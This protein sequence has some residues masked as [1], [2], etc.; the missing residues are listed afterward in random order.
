[1]LVE[2]ATLGVVGCSFE[3]LSADSPRGVRGVSA[4]VWRIDVVWA[5]MKGTQQNY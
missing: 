1:M 2:V 5:V 4:K 3:L